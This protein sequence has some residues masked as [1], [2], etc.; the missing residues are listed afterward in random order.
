MRETC[1]AWDNLSGALTP[2]G[3]YSADGENDRID[4]WLSGYHALSYNLLGPEDEF[5]AELFLPA[6]G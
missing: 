4:T 6:G 1:A 5:V 3:S 2:D